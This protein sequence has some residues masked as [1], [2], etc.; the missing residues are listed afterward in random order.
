MRYTRWLSI[1]SPLLLAWG[2][3][4]RVAGAQQAAGYA[5]SKACTSECHVKE[6]AEFA[7]TS[8]G[9]LFLQHPRSE[10]EK[11]GCEGCHGPGAK[12][13][14]SGGEDFTGMVVFSRKTKT[15]VA[16]RNAVCLRCHDKT[17]R[18]LWG[19]STHE[20]R[21]VACTD[22]HDVMRN[23]SERGNL[24]KATVLETCAQCHPQRKTQQLRFAHMPMQEGKIECTN[25]HNPHGGPN[26]KMLV[27]PSVNET[28]YGCHPEK[29]GPFLWEHNPVTENCANCHD[30]HGTSHEMMLKVSRPRLCQQCHDGTGHPVLPRN[31]AV[32]ADI[33]FVFNR[34]C[35]N[36][37][38]NIH[39]SNHPSGKYFTR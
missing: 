33:Q 30:A 39:G 19:G 32:P 16:E 1:L 3:A 37:H 22:C 27:A 8:K 13:I 15:P 34:Q 26:D 21:D 2:I 14:D 5:G 12:H 20:S 38:V 10:M 35:Q 18:T 11:L 4:P 17:A 24:K 29:R 23:T 6:S 36:C 28:C 25:C 9:K 7:A 31:P